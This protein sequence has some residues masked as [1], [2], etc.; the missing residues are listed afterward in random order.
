M[1][2]RA[3]FHAP[4]AP[5]RAGLRHSPSATATRPPLLAAAAAEEDEEEAAEEDEEDEVERRALEG[6][7]APL[8][9]V[10]SST[11]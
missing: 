3:A 1:A 7:K 5:E 11:S 10:G 6:S 4:A 2:S 9:R 8:A